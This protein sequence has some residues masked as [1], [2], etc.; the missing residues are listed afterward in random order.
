M[1]PFKVVRTLLRG[2]FAQYFWNLRQWKRGWGN[3][4]GIPSWKPGWD[5]TQFR[6]KFA[7]AVD[8]LLCVLVF[9]GPVASMSWWMNLH[10]QGKVW[11]FVLDGIE[12]KDPNHGADAGGPLWGTS[13]CSFPIRVAVPVLW[14]L[15]VKWLIPG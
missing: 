9:A 3:F 15:L 6:W 10:R 4:G 5:A 12:S 7:Y 2:L 14:V 1:N 13:E 11:D 8:Y